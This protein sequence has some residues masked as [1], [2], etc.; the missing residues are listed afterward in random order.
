M[1]LKDGTLYKGEWSKDKENGL[2][3]VKYL[4]GDEETSIYTEGKKYNLI[5]SL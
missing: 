5:N 1:T 3:T 4:N 2:G